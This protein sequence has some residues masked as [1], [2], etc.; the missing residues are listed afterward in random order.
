M[1]WRLDWG[2]EGRRGGGERVQDSKNCPLERQE[3]PCEREEKEKG[4]CRQESPKAEPG[5]K[6][7]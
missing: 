2:G 4:L 5:V 1:K 3:S 6:C 7:R